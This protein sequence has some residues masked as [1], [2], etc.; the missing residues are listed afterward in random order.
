MRPEKATTFSGLGTRGGSKWSDMGPSI[1]GKDESAE[2]SPQRR[3]ADAT[4]EI[5]TN[6]MRE[7]TQGGNIGV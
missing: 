6:R 3:A 4:N 7:M 5:S 1:K 2:E